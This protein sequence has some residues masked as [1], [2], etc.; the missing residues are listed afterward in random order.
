MKKVLVIALAGLCLLTACVSQGR[1]MAIERL[2]GEEF[3]RLELG[4]A[5][6]YVEAGWTD[7]SGTSYAHVTLSEEQKKN[8]LFDYWE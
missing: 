7:T 2:I 1:K 3:E 5:D 8:P 4:A 6:A